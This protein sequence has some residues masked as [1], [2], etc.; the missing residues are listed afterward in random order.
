MFSNEANNRILEF[1]T[2]AAQLG[3]FMYFN[4]ERIQGQFIWREI[5]HCAYPNNILWPLVM[6]VKHT[7]IPVHLQ[8][9]LD[10]N[11]MHCTGVHLGPKLGC[12]R[13]QH[14]NLINLTL[15]T[16]CL[17]LFQLVY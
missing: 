9:W 5:G 12:S 6:S 8:N 2:N 3:L 16:C 10:W 7:N 4:P 15:D 11:Q 14:S 13:T 17:C 1:A